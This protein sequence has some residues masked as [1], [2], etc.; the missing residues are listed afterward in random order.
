MRKWSLSK[1]KRPIDHDKPQSLLSLRLC[2]TLLLQL[3]F[4]SG[5]ASMGETSYIDSRLKVSAGAEPGEVFG[6]IAYPTNPLEK[7]PRYMRYQLSFKQLDTNAEGFLVLTDTVFDP[8]NSFDVPAGQHRGKSF[9]LML[10]PGEYELANARMS[11]D[12]GQSSVYF[13]QSSRS[14]LHFQ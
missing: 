1:A 5:C 6:S 9:R 3:F 4:L 10:S 8:E 13:F 11:S 12:N 14:L 2:A 7:E